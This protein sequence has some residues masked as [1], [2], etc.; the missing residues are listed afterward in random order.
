MSMTRKGSFLSAT[1]QQQQHSPQREGQQAHWEQ[2]LS[3]NPQMFGAEP[4]FAAC[5]AAKT[6][7]AHGAREVLELGAGQGRDTLHLAAQGLTVMALDYAEAGVQAVTK[8]AQ[9]QG[10]EHKV[11]AARHDVRQPLPLD[12]ETCD[13]CYA[14]MLL[15]MALTKSELHTLVDEVRRVL[16]PGGLFL[17]TVR[18]EGDPHYGTGLHGGENLYE[19]GGFMVHYFNKSMVES[20]ATGFD[21]LEVHAFEEG[22]LPRRLWRVSLAKPKT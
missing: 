2:N 9:A 17:Y 12:N 21:M 10:L 5:H 6:F 22:P 11:R 16:R 7:L 19:T 1:S 8:A 13:A 3:Q 4:S 14:H 18:H 15:C 20:L